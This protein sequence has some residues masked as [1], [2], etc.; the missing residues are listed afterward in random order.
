MLI[1]ILGRWFLPK[2]HLSRDE[3]SSL[4]LVYLG[5]AADI[6]EFFQIFDLQRFQG[7]DVN[8]DYIT[9]VLAVWT[10][11]L[12]QFTLPLTAKPLFSKL[13]LGDDNDEEEPVFCEEVQFDPSLSEKERK[14]ERKK[15]EQLQKKK[16]KE[17]QKEMERRR[18]ATEKK[19]KQLEKA[20]QGTL[21]CSMET[22]STWL[23]IFMQDG[24]FLAVRLV[25]IIEYQAYE[26]NIFYFAA[27]NLIVILLLL[28]R[29]ITLAC[30]PGIRGK[31]MRAQQQEVLQKHTEILQEERRLS[32][33]DQSNTSVDLLPSTSER[34]QPRHSS[35][36]SLPPPRSTETGGNGYDNHAFHLL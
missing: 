34:G 16:Q 2:G 7:F 17:L 18:R 11:S 27:K 21:C 25:A 36:T 15:S 1:I 26:Y 20:A 10:L 9:V 12:F 24:P 23:T 31:M 3:L 28:Y 8:P 14:R 30:L 5:L 19:R 22:W 29:F 32:Q 13:I 33:V 35:S 4:L 6:A